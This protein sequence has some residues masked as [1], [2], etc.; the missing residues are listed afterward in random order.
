M[1]KAISLILCAVLAIGCMLPAFAADGGVTVDG[2]WSIL[3]PAEPTSYESFAAGKLQS[4]LAEVFG[5]EI[6]MVSE[7]AG[8]YIA[9]GAASAIDPAG[10]ADNGYR[11][12]VIDGNIHLNGAGVRGLQVG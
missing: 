5:T 12:K 11:I 10:I 4:G 8:N 2:T 7:P 3:V 1:K 9:V 6:A